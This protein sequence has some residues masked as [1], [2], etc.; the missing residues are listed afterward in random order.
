LINALLSNGSVNKPQQQKGNCVL[1]A[2]RAEQKHVARQRS[3][4]HASTTMGDGV[5]REVG[6]KELSWKQTVLRF[7]SQ[8]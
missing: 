5:F 3:S 8:F 1:Y 7:S 2:V 6:S 4:K